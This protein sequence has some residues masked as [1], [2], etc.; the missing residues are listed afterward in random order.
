MSEGC[1]ATPEVK[2]ILRAMA[3][4]R[5]EEAGIRDPSR[6]VDEIHDAIKEHTPLEKSQIADIVSGFGARR[7]TRSEVENTMASIRAEMRDLSKTQEALG[8][9]PA[10]D[11]RI[12][13]RVS[14]LKNEIADLDR[15]INFPE[16][17]KKTSEPV[18]SPAID[19]LKKQRDDK[20]LELKNLEP[21][22]PPTGPKH[23]NEL[24]NE[25]RMKVL[26]KQYADAQNRLMTGDVAKEA[27]ENDNK[28][29]APSL[30][31][32]YDS[33][34]FKM[35]RKVDDQRMK[36]AKAQLQIEKNSRS[37]TQKVADMAFA[38]KRASILSGFGTIGKLSAASLGRIGLTPMENAI[39]SVYS[40]IPVLSRIAAK[41]PS[42]GAGFKASATAEGE[43]LRH[44]F[45]KDTGSQMLK[46]LK[47]GHDTIDA[48]SNSDK[49][50]HS[51]TLL[52]VVGHVHAMLKEPAKINQFY[53]SLS[54]RSQ[55]EA[56]RVKAAGMSDAEV[57][58][59]MADPRTQA[60]ITAKSAED[61]QR[62][63]LQNKNLFVSL[64]QQLQARLK[65]E[66]QK[67]NSTTAPFAAVTSRAM[68][69]M[70][71]IVK[72]PTNLVAEGGSYMLGGAKA[73]IALRHGIDKLTPDQADY[74][75]R[76]LKK[77]TV[78]A[79]LMAIGFSAGP[80]T[81]GGYYQQGDN[82]KHRPIKADESSFAGKWAFHTAATQMLQLG[83]TV[84]RVYDETR[85]STAGKAFAGVKAG[86]GGLIEQ[87]PF[88]DTPQHIFKATETPTSMAKLA[89]Q[90]ARA[91]FIPQFLQEAAK[92]H[93]GN[94][95]THYPRGF[96][97]ELKM[98]I[99]GLRE[100]VPTHPKP[101]E[102][103]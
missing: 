60:M 25:R 40:H 41:A 56:A 32:W 7:A 93:E 68:E 100:T 77:Q 37:T 96:V 62:T 80:S 12:K 95:V 42:E 69:Y 85:G 67:K 31:S 8:D 88:F 55:H 61:A 19:A 18:T 83:A 11:P 13:A 9:N 72:V 78:G 15:R 89:G 16:A 2:S 49:L 102:R 30:K 45:S 84:R 26:E 24:R 53:R 57:Q 3:K 28:N 98:G 46:V 23:P 90:E 21:S 52:D 71:P 47:E 38:V 34:T 82:K 58:T 6:I 54:L 48:I 50:V 91:S 75:M 76:N 22:P 73:A 63:I 14:A 92:L 10:D 4:N 70:M 27:H 5:A 94:D 64:Y 44:T 79:A 65:N 101:V 74:V 33:D 51:H 86:V 66:G 1:D 97:D 99:P 36:I 39:G 103:Y 59:H 87:V 17:G 20:K 43:A 81:F 29:I 35:Q